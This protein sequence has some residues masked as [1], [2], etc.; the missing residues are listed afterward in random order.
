A[1]A[2]A[3]QSVRLDAKP[4]SR[5]QPDQRVERIAPPVPA[6]QENNQLGAH[7]SSEVSRVSLADRIGNTPTNKSTNP[8]PRPFEYLRPSRAFEGLRSACAFLTGRAHTVGLDGHETGLTTRLAHA[9]EGELKTGLRVL[10]V[11]VGIVGG[12]ATLMPLSGAVIVPGTLVV[13]S[14]VKKIK[15]PS[16]GVVANIP[17][18]DGMHVRSGDLLLHLDETQ[19]RANSQVLSQQLDQT[20]VRLAR[21]IAERDGF[22]Q[23][24]MPHEIAGRS[25]DDDVTRLWASETSLFNSRAATRRNAKEA[26]RSHVGQ[27]EEQISGLDAQVKSKAAQHE[28]ISG[29]LEGVEGLY[30]K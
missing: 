11:G 20:R 18:R 26:L 5:P 1:A 8:A 2:F 3:R 16:G 24:Q 12:W 6:A 21:L 13:E 29:E 28:L 22:D 30:Q 19:L 10:I 14:N 17:A 15:P 25:N 7:S 23:P 4:P 27:L 9:F